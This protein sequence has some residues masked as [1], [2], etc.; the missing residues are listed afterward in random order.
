[1]PDMPSR[2]KVRFADK[3]IAAPSEAP[4]ATPRVNGVASGFLKMD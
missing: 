2:L 1:M 4:D 3:A